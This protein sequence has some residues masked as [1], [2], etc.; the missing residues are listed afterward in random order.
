LQDRT[1][2]G[3]VPLLARKLSAGKPAVAAECL[4]C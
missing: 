2:E 4:G 3:D 1:F